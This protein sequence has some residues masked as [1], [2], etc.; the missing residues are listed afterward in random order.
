MGWFTALRSASTEEEAENRLQQAYEALFAGRGS[1][2]DAE[3]VLADLR[4]FCG[5]DAVNEAVMHPNTLQYQSG[6]RSV[7]GRIHDNIRL[8]DH[9]RTA[10]EKAVRELSMEPIEDY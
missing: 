9:E 5:F 3:I 1:K 10:L 4:N 2:E 7:F 6:R 8:T